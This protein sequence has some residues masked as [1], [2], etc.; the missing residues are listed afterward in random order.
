M[1]KK[2]ECIAVLLKKKNSKYLKTSMRP[3]QLLMRINDRY[4]IVR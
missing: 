3:L 4:L 1:E 2:N